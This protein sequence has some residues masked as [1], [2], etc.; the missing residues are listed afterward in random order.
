MLQ[1]LNPEW[2]VSIA[3]NYDRD[4]TERAVLFVH[5]PGMGYAFDSTNTGLDSP[6]AAMAMLSALGLYELVDPYAP[7]AR[8]DD[9]YVLLDRPGEHDDPRP[10]ELRGPHPVAPIGPIARTAVPGYWRAA[11]AANG[12]TCQLMFVTGVDI[13]QHPEALP[14]DLVTAAHEC[15]VAGATVRVLW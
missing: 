14:A 2:G 15:R 1:T 8:S 3:R 5:S 9:W 13:H 11:A 6:F 12:N 10:S 4:G 7:A